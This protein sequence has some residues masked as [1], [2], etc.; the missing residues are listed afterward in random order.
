[1]LQ[2]SY[3]KFEKSKASLANHL[4]LLDVYMRTG[5]RAAG[6]LGNR[7]LTIQHESSHTADGHLLYCSG[8]GRQVSQH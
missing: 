4:I 5:V 2:P 3:L 6:G 1:M 7:Q 8:E